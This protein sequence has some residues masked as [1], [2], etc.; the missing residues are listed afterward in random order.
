MISAL[1]IRNFRAIADSEMLELGPGLT[2]LIGPNGAGKSSLVEALRLLHEAVVTDPTRAL[3][4]WRG[5]ASVRHRATAANE[6]VSIVLKMREHA[7]KLPAHYLLELQQAQNGIDVLVEGEVLFRKIGTGPGK[8]RDLL[9]SSR[10]KGKVR[11]EVSKAWVPFELSD[12]ELAIR[13]HA[14]RARHKHI[15]PFAEDIASWRFVNPVPALMRPPTP[16]SVDSAWQETGISVALQLARATKEQIA[17]IS[18]RLTHLVE[19]TA[20]IDAR[21]ASEGALIELKEQVHQGLFPSWTLSD[22][23]LR[24]LAI[25]TALYVGSPPGLLCVEEPENSLHPS[26]ID[27]LL[28]EFRN[29]S[30]RGTQVL[31]TTHSPHLLNRL[32]LAVDTAYFVDRP[33]GAARFTRLP[34]DERTRKEMERY[35]LGELLEQGALKP[36]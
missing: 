26:V 21:L 1:C 16:L 9:V 10:G 20:A 31:I 17:T 14:D 18:R 19:G 11:D 24:I 2:A 7:T 5:W 23:T 32:N 27:S 28:T 30:E 34:A 6:P 22:G 29:A 3:S 25:L 15:I 35:G 33:S 4:R 12:R 36:A 8:K 13:Y